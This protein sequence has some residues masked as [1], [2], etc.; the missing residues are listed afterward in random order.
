MVTGHAIYEMD[1][2]PLHWRAIPS[3]VGDHYWRIVGGDPDALLIAADWN[4]V[5]NFQRLIKW[6]RKTGKITDLAMIQ[7]QGC[8]RFADI[9]RGAY[10]DRNQ[11]Q[12][13]DGNRDLVVTTDGGK[14]WKVNKNIG[15]QPIRCLYWVNSSRLV[16]GEE[17]EI[18]AFDLAADRTLKRVWST[19]VQAVVTKLFSGS[20]GTAWFDASNRVAQV[21]LASGK[22][23]DGIDTQIRLNVIAY[24]GKRLWLAGDEGAQVFQK[25]GAGW[26][27]EKDLTFPANGASQAGEP[28]HGWV[29]W[30]VLPKSGSPE[31]IGGDGGSYSWDG[32]SGVLALRSLS[33]DDTAVKRAAAAEK[34]RQPTMEQERAL[35]SWMGGVREAQLGDA[36]RDADQQQSAKTWT[37]RQRMDWLI[38]QIHKEALANL[39]AGWKPPA[40]APGDFGGALGGMKIFSPSSGIA[41]TGEGV[42]VSDGDLDHWKAVARW[43]QPHVWAKVVGAAPRALFAV[44]TESSRVAVKENPPRPSTV[45]YNDLE[46]L[47]IGGKDQLFREV[48]RDFLWRWTRQDGFTKL[49]ELPNSPAT[50]ASIC[51]FAD[52]RSGAFI[53]GDTVEVTRD[54]GTTWTSSPLTPTGISHDPARQIVFCGPDR[55]EVILG[56]NILASLQIDRAGAAHEQ[57]RQPMFANGEMSGVNATMQYDS[58]TKLMLLYG[59]PYADPPQ[60]QLVDPDS[61]NIIRTWPAVGRH[62]FLRGW[63]IES[64]S[65]DVFV[66]DGQARLCDFSANSVKET[67]DIQVQN[68]EFTI[69]AVFHVPGRDTVYLLLNHQRLVKWNGKPLIP[70][71]LTS[72][73]QCAAIDRRLLDAPPATQPGRKN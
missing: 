34:L 32:K 53:N 58:Q 17:G 73:F 22:I 59:Q 54:A 13:M 8:C 50:G 71:H 28:N 26:R 7:Y 15:T 30:I 6:D 40:R 44:E 56:E 65:L 9:H 33:V 19:P 60:F 18:E 12:V 64:G 3:L 72:D 68:N 29:Q 67:A 25:A 70:A 66:T 11:D 37:D 47:H 23:I 52:D 38:E 55:L 69:T 62:E 63:Q 43:N 4:L 46:T 57:W 27:L 42:F 48:R 45:P 20:A 49:R 10:V 36:E 35:L 31:L 21:D 41:L 5:N 16:A 39:A 24:D 2:D 61:G 51:A 14:S 1:R